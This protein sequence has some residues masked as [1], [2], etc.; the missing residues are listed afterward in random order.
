MRPIGKLCAIAVAGAPL[1]AYAR[2]IWAQDETV[3]TSSKLRV[4]K[5]TGPVFVDPRPGRVPLNLGG[6]I[7]QRTLERKLA[8]KTNDQVRAAVAQ[9]Q[10]QQ[11]ADTYQANFQNN[12]G[13]GTLAY[14]DYS[15]YSHIGFGPGVPAEYESVGAG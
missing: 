8:L 6:M 11:R 7:D 3:T 13:L 2:P 9:S 10:A 5:K 15:F 12:S 1:F 14:L 4:D